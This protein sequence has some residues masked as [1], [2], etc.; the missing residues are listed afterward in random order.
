MESESTS[1]AANAFNV[2]DRQS[3]TQFMF[4]ALAYRNYRLFFFGQGVSLIGTWLTTT[5]TSWLVFR[6]AQGNLLVKAATV[7]GIVRFAGQIPMFALAPAA[8]VLVDRWN[9]HRVLV[10]AQTLSMLQSAALAALALSNR[11]TILQVIALNVV[12]GA[13]NAFDASARQ[14]FVVEMVERREDLPNAIALNS[15]VFNGARLLGPAIAGI[16][17]WRVGEGMCFAIDALSYLAVI[18]ALL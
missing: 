14:A 3:I 16:L 2:A 17:I 18:I 6:L 8:G 9:R 11:I 12:Q 1:S 10:I 13:V 4:R 15:S 7:L 5:A